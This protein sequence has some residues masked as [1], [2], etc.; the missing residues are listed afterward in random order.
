MRSC[1]LAFDSLEARRLLSSLIITHGG[2]Y[3][4]TWESDNPKVAAVII[5]TAEPVIIQNATI[6]SKSDLIV[7][8]VDHAHIT[9]RNCVGTALNPNVAGQ[10]PGRFL[11][12]FNFSSIDIE[13]NDLE[14]T[15]GIHLLQFAGDPTKGDTIKILHNRAHNIDGRKSNGFGGWLSY[16]SRVSLKDGHRE[17]GFVE[18]QFVQLDK[19]VAV[20]GVQIAWNQ[21]INDPGNSRVEDNISIFES[22]GTKL[23]PLVIH[24]NYIQGA[25]TIRPTQGTYQDSTW[26]YD[27]SYS[28]GGIMLG[29]G[30]RIDSAFVRAYDN[31]I[32]STTNYG[33]AESAGHDLEAFD[34]RIVS[35]GAISGKAIA[36]Q[37]VGLYVWDS[38]RTGSSHFYNDS[39]QNNAVGWIKNGK[40]NDWWAPVMSILSN[41]TRWAGTI[42]AT[43]ESAEF[44]RWQAKL[45]VAAAEASRSTLAG[46]VY[47]DMNGNGAIDSIDHGIGG[48]HIYIDANND[49]AWEPNEP[50]TRTSSNGHWQ[51]TVAP[52]TY[53]V[54][55]QPTPGWRSTK[56]DSAM[57]KV[58]QVNQTLTHTFAVSRTTLVTGTV[59][60]DANANGHFDPGESPLEGWLIFS[61]GNNNG[62]LDAGEF[63]ATTD[64]LGHFKFIGMSAANHHLRVVPQANYRQTSP[65]AQ[66]LSVTLT[67]A[68][69]VDVGGFG[70]KRV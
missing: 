69:V 6:K 62:K 36:A 1:A 12:T 10:S 34:N 35:V 15:S 60:M 13:N 2:I 49:G 27:W 25:Y 4:G 8:G 57:L 54:R 64:S 7:T 45:N 39:A 14:S 19:C 28:G 41:N 58:T 31:Q 40:R 24:D 26:K 3:T 47:N 55:V 17:N 23:S 52:G 67:A 53:V 38:Y 66:Y 68:Q 9:V 20:P 30:A 21:V 43:T 63:T 70:E 11:S 50:I 65:A 37:N 46:T 61:D 56:G 18:A 22:S 59:F 32:V 33:I 51:F 29:D 42:S 5:R 44:S 16:N 48:F